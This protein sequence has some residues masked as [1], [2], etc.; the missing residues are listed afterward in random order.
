MIK[1]KV[2]I[3]F[4]FIPLFSIGQEAKLSET[5][6][7]VAE[8]LAA[9]ETE[10]GAAEVFAERLYEL[11]SDPVKI[12]SGDE[13]EISRLF[14]LTGFQVKVL[15]DYVKS[16]GRIVSPFEI[17]NIPG[18][19]KETTGMMIPFITFES[20]FRSPGDSVRIR[21]TLL[22][23]FILKSSL[24]DTV[25]Q[26]SPWKILIKYKFLAGSFSGGFTMEK[27]PG[28]K[29]LY[30]NPPVP[31]FFSAHMTYKGSGFIKKIVIG[32]YSVRFG[33][34]TGINTGIRTG[35]SL[36]TPGYLAGK[37]EIRPYTSA[38]ENN[39]FRGAAAELSLK[40]FDLSIFFSSNKIDATL[41]DSCSSIRSLYITGLHNSPGTIL[42]KDAISEITYGLSLS[43]NF[44]NLRTGILWTEDRFSLP[45]VPEIVNPADNYDFKGDKNSLYTIYYNCLLKR[46]IF[47]GEF[48]NSGLNRYAFVQGMSLRPADRLNINFI[49]RNY[50]TQFVS[51]HGNG[52]A[53]SSVNNNESGILGN[54]T[55]EAAR[56]LFISAGSDIRSFPWLRYRC[57]SPSTGRK[58]EIRLRY[59]PSDK[60]SLEALYNY[61]YTMVDNPSEKGVPVQNEVAVQ[62]V[63]GYIKYAPAENV[64]IG[65]R[66]D[67]KSV[68]PSGSKG[69]LLLQDVSIRFRR[70]P[71]SIWARY[72]IFN[73]DGFE[74]GLYTWENDLLNSFSIPAMYGCGSRSYIMASWQPAEKVE[75]RFKFAIATKKAAGNSYNNTS[76]IKIQLKVDI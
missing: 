62:S 15:A 24:S 63:R 42:K 25:S 29:L 57:S 54:I 69:M 3:L 37:N 66:L 19:D 49:Y 30:G 73:T 76:E 5:I 75:L 53:G 59:L 14:F 21:H 41:N 7:A 38:D 40:K 48:S 45:F 74:S 11:T 28:E 56:F 27:D 46:F 70:I 52:P 33:L 2:I 17:A 32:D 61:R 23:N 4:T 44:N 20:S 8:E 16:A 10:A 26:D 12:N 35:L 1:F 22:S 31:D 34:G 64:G 36:T 51:F 67:Y 60:L 50:S 58:H 72:C 68:D 39:F 47:F 55:F 65:I 13:D 18:F 9:E 71:V 43:Y 6:A